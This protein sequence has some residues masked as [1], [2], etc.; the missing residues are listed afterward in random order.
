M[1]NLYIVESPLQA[2]CA[3]ELSLGNKNELHDII[4]RTSG[5]RSIRNDKQMLV[6]VE[7]FNWNCKTIISNNI[8]LG[9]YLVNF[10]NKYFLNRIRKK[11]H[12]K[13]KSLYIGEFLSSF[14]H[15]T[16]LA[17]NAPNNFLLDDGAVTVKVINNYINNG[18]NYPYDT[19]YPKNTI[20]KLVFKF[21]YRKHLDLVSLNSN[22]KIITAF[23]EKEDNKIIKLNFSNIKK[24]NTHKKIR[25]R[26]L[27]YYFGAPYSETSIVSS[28]YETGL[29]K[30]VKCFYE[31]E[32]KTILYFPHRNESREKLDFIKSDLG[33]EIVSSE[34]TAELYLLESNVL[35]Y[36][37]A[38]AY[39]SVLNNVKVIFPEISVRSFK[40]DSKN[41]LRAN[42]E[43]ESLYKYYKSIGIAVQN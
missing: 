35:P 32:N 38:G 23:S 15:M 40:L 11:Y 36:E 27:V 24:I 26:S 1:K 43:I 31:K 37:I 28:D 17:V 25:N 42:V 19:F 29:L 14:M 41:I 12:N 13:V 7:K 33:F 3:L 6:I 20:K 5:G 8:K 16:R 9:R 4:V 34:L 2:L 18:Y 21:I 30:K 22:I 39:T 10:E